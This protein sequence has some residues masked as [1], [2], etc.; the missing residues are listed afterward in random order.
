MSPIDKAKL[1]VYRLPETLGYAAVVAWAASRMESL[2]E[3]RERGDVSI[4]T[5]I[6][7]VAGITL[8]LAIATVITVTLLNK[9]KSKLSSQ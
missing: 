6:I 1:A 9:Y 2:K 5:V 8:A 4:T 3:E 7:W